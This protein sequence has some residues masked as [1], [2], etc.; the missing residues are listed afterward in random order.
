MVETQE[1]SIGEYL[2][3]EGLKY[4]VLGLA[5]WRKKVQNS[6]EIIG[7][8]LA[9]AGYEETHE[10]TGEPIQVYRGK[11]DRLFFVKVGNF[12]TPQKVVVYRQM[13]KGALYPEGQLWWRP[14]KN[15][16]K[17]FIRLEK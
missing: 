7:I 8:A 14:R 1:I 6:V 12:K 9:V 11:D 17:H 16:L 4:N 2:H 15:F 3:S 10:V 5:R 13:E